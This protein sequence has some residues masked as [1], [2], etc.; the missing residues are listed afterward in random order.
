ML[1]TLRPLTCV[2]SFDGAVFIK[3]NSD[4]IHDHLPDLDRAHPDDP[5][6]AAHEQQRPARVK[7]DLGGGGP[8]ELAGNEPLEFKKSYVLQQSVD[9]KYF[10][11]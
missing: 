8:A 10:K 6:H 3:Y 11:I 9:I 4:L 2:T 5:A 1:P 7:L